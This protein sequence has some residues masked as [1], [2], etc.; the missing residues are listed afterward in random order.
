M[1][2]LGGL[3]DPPGAIFETGWNPKPVQIGAPDPERGLRV[4]CGGDAAEKREP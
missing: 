1:P 3:I 4:S 2:C